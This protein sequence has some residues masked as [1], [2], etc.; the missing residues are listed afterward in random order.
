MDAVEELKESMKLELELFDGMSLLQPLHTIGC[1]DITRAGKQYRYCDILIY[2]TVAIHMYNMVNV[3]Y[4]YSRTLMIHFFCSEP[5]N[6]VKSN[7][8]SNVLTINPF[9]LAHSIY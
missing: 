6:Y 9:S 1:T 5:N 8:L 2:L 3:L 7:Y 4:M